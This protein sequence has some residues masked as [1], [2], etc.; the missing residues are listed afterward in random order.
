[1]GSLVVHM[2]DFSI[3]VGHLYKM[4]SDEILQHYVPNF[5]RSSIL[6]EAHRGATG[7]HYAGKVTTQ[8]ILHAGLWWPTMHKDS[9]AYC[10]ACDTC[11]RTGK[12]SQRYELPMIPQVMLQ[13]FK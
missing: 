11:Q 4:G 1:M 6:V 13:P 8:K 7:R 3:I 2:T 12:P 10:R 9:K 5:E